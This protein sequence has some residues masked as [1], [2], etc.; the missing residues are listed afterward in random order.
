[1]DPRVAQE[2]V[3]TQLAEVRCGG[4]LLPAGVRQV[5]S[6]NIIPG[7]QPY[8]GPS[9]LPPEAAPWQAQNRAIH[10]F[11]EAGRRGEEGKAYR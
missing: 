7:A 6:L 10:S 4:M 8:L 5:E 2:Q 9:L 1:M 3:G 11:E